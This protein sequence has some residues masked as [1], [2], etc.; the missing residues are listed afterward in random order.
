MTA[1]R[2]AADEKAVIEESLAHADAVAKDRA[3]AERRRRVD[4]DDRDAVGRCAVCP[5]ETIDQRALAAAGRAGDADDLRVTG[6]RIQRPHGL[7]GTSLVVLDDGEQ[8]RDRTFVAAP[9]TLEQ[10][11][12]G[13]GHEACRARSFAMTM[14]WTSLV[15]SP[16]SMRRASRRILSTG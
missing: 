1:A 2:H 16:I 3:A 11:G 8:T 6:Q 9:R 10:V 15:P 13:D 4:R 7:G 5:R 14:R 12:R